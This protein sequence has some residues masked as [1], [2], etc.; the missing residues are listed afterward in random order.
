MLEQMKYVNHLGETIEFG[1][2]GLYANY[3]EIRD[4]TWTYTRGYRK[5]SKFEYDSSEKELPV[6]IAGDTEEIA[7]T[8]KNQLNDI[9][10]KDVIANTAGKLFIGDEYLKCFVIA[11]EKSDFLESKKVMYAKLTIIPET[12]NVWITEK[13]YAFNYHNN[14]TDTEG[15]GG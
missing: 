2:N 4:K 1:K 13:N 8:L 6:V 14:A 15:T 9:V 5:V 11:S 7:V 12:F 3:S 10:E